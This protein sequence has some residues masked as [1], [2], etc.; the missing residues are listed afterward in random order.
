MA[1]PIQR[2]SDPRLYGITLTKPFNQSYQWI[3]TVSHPIHPKCNHLAEYAVRIMKVVTGILSVAIT[4]APALIGRLIQI[5]HYH[6]LS[7]EH[8]AEPPVVMIPGRRLPT[9]QPCDLPRQKVF[10]GTDQESAISILRWG[11]DP[12]KCSLEAKMGEAIYVS[13]DDAVSVSYG[14]DQLILSLDLREE[15]VAYITDQDLGEFA[16]NGV[17]K[18]VR[19]LAIQ[20]G[21]RAIKYD[22]SQSGSE[23][24]W[25]VYDTS[26]I[27]ITE[28][29]P[30]PVAMLQLA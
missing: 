22:L 30:S 14:K 5:I 27:T 9:L 6:T 16:P 25:A 26:C 21:Y 18:A 23:E 29:R 2:Y 20:N 4:G 13:A 28:V 11:F 3:R 15:E 24:A 1:A 8:R 19:E 17:E 10:H 12:T 7:E